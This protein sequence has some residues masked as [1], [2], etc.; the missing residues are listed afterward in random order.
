MKIETN[1]DLDDTAYAI[2][3]SEI[4]EHEINGIKI[5]HERD[6]NVFI[7]KTIIKYSVTRVGTLF[8]ES[9]LY[10]TPE[11]A[12]MSLVEKFNRK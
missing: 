6:V 10:K 12:A 1:F 7:P 4:V 11:E 5:E 3:E 9:Q 8:L 2:V